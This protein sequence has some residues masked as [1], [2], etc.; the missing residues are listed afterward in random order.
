[1]FPDRAIAKSMTMKR[2]KASY[3]MQD[4]IA[5]VEKDDITKICQS[6]MFSL[7]IDESTD[8]SVC[9]ILAVVVRYYDEDKCQVVDALL[10]S[11]EVYDASGEGL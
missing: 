8:I 2:T 6:N 5:K 11:I 3:V 4:G 1:M 7:I 9:Q 10:D